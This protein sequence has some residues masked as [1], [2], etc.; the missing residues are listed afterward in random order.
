MSPHV[1]TL[2]RSITIVISLLENSLTDLRHLRNLERL[3]PSIQ[4][5]TGVVCIAW[6]IVCCLD[7]VDVALQVAS[8][9]EK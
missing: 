2:I 5:L 1:V 7:I 4:S 8:S 6:F 3:I 9:C